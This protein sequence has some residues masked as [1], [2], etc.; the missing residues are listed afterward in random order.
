[1]ALLSGVTDL[2][3]DFAA[4]RD[5]VR[6]A[7]MSAYMKHRFAFFG[8]PAPARRAIAKVFV[9]SGAGLS[10]GGLIEHAESCWVQ[11]EREFQYVGADL[12]ARWAPRLTP[13]DIEAVGRLITTKPWWDT[14]DTLAV[15]VVGSLVATHPDV[16]QVMDQWIEAD[17]IWLARTALLH[18]LRYGQATDAERLFRYAL[19]RADDTEFFIRKAIGWALR[20]YARCE[21]EA[22]RTFVVEH[23]DD[24]SALTRREALKHLAT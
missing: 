21:P 24:F 17:D 8:V 13:D 22:V 7:Q 20:Q 6:A 10:A 5:Q 19:L 3:A 11:P 15:H 1:M 16:R 14:V 18:Q 2:R 9:A 23:G 4:H 12:L